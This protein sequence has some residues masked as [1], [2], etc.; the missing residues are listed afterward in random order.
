MV[1]HLYSREDPRHKSRQG[2]IMPN[3]QTPEVRPDAPEQQP[4]WLSHTPEHEQTNHCLHVDSAGG[5]V[6]QEVK[7]T[8]VEYEFLKRS[9]AVHRGLLESSGPLGI[10]EEIRAEVP[11]DTTAQRKAPAW[12]TT[13]EDLTFQL[14]VLDW[15]NTVDHD[16]QHIKL[17]REEHDILRDVLACLRIDN[18]VHYGDAHPPEGK[19]V[20]R[21]ERVNRCSELRSFLEKAPAI[22]RDYG[23]L[24]AEEEES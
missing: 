1:R 17:S 7:F 15:N 16:L 2:E 20:S 21:S 5:D 10:G 11:A 24:L 8:R 6:P 4:E 9:L 23:H 12:L 3:T 22:V 13:P 18:A 14:S 19:E